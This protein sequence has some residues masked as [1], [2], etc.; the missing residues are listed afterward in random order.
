MPLPS[1]NQAE[2]PP[3]E[4]GLWNRAW[5]M[6]LLCAVLVVLDWALVPVMVFPFVFIFPIM[7]VAWNRGLWL[8]LAVAGAMSLTRIVHQFVIAQKPVV[9]DEFAD[10]LLCFFVL[11][12]LATLTTLLGR[13]S[14]QLRHRVRLLEGMLPI[15]SFC[16]SIRNETGD[17]VQLEKYIASHTEATFTHG[18]CQNCA[19]EHYR[20][21]LPPPPKT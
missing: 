15:C 6:L 8:S 2:L 14:R 9:V 1:F 3:F 19:K 21:F 4:R 7:L 18:L 12:L 17:W 13:Q 10:A 11:V 20:D 5:F 16:K